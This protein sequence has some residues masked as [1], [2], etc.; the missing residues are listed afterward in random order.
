MRKLLIVDDDAGL[1]KAYARIGADSGFEVHVVSDP[2]K[3][4]E[5]FLAFKPDVAMIDMIMPEKDGIDVLNEVLLTGQPA[6][7]IVTSGYG[8]A[9]LRLAKGLA[10]FHASGRVTVL[11]K[12]IRR[13][14]LEKVL[15]GTTSD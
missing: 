13:A 6:R 8:D 9:M 14:E 5:A 12:P 3:A 11:K 15:T 1:A 10:D 7:I 4:T 2:L